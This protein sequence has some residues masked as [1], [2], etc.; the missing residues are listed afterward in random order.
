M[1]KFDWLAI[2]FGC[3]LLFLLALA[4]VGFVYEVINEFASGDVTGGILGVVFFPMMLIGDCFA[5]MLVHSL[6][7]AMHA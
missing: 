5:V 7:K 2:S 6:W 1:S 4:N 3:Y